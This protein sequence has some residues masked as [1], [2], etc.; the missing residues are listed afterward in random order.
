MSDSPAAIGCP[1]AAA[2]AQNEPQTSGTSS[3]E[4]VAAAMLDYPILRENPYIVPGVFG[5]LREEQPMSRIR[6]PNGD[7]AWLATRHADA[8]TVLAD[9]R[10]SAD[11]TRAGFPRFRKGFPRLTAGTDKNIVSNHELTF[12]RMDPPE[13]TRIRRMLT[14]EFTVRRAEQMRPRLQEMVDG[15]VDAM[16]TA[17]PPTDEKPA[18]LVTGLAVP[19]PSLVICEI[20]GVPYED[21]DFF[22]EHSAIIMSG[23]TTQRQ[24]LGS[25]KAMV[26]YFEDLATAKESLAEPSDDLFGRLIEEYVRPGELSHAELVTTTRLLFIAGHETTANMLGLCFVTLLTQRDQL[27]L[28]REQPELIPG[29]VEE[30]LRYFTIVEAGLPRVAVQDVMVGDQL[31]RAGE[32]VVASVVSGN[33]DAAKFDDADVLD[34]TKSPHGH[35][36]FGFG[37]HQCLGQAL[38][39]LELRTAIETVL[40]RLP[41]I[42]LAVPAADVKFHGVSLVYGIDALPVVW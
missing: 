28:L 21:R 11:S 34:V 36:S 38:A 10:F 5:R 40:R 4:S 6:M 39:R 3:P 33:R 9:P 13:H 23:S 16:L 37:P 26:K 25:L 31:V 2:G 29:A 20:L 17:G 24:S 15:F 18:D 19:L 35:L 27:E 1:Y 22:Q 42:R 12:M 41:D 7:V 8:R 32:G 14:R 30:L